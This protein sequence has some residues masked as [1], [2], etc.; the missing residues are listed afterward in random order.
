MNFREISHVVSKLG[1]GPIWNPQDNCVTWTDISQKVIH[2]AD[3]DSGITKSLSSKNMIGALAFTRD[4]NLVAA[5]QEGFAL[6]DTNGVFSELNSFLSSDMRM[7][8]GKVDPNGRFWAGS[9]ALDFEKNR[10]SLYV[11]ERD[12][13][14]KKVLD[15]IT[16][17]NGMGWS[18][19]QKYFYFIDSI[20]GV[21]KRFDYDSE[22]GKIQNQVDLIVFDTDLGIPDG[23]SVCS[24]GKLVVA[25]WDGSRVEIYEPSGEKCGQICLEV[26]R[27]TSCTFGG[28][29]LDVLIVT[30][31]SQD[32]NLQNEVLAGKTLAITESGLSGQIAFR[33][34]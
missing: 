3:L 21:L 22:S 18:P 15:N 13:S 23:M 26:S 27:P 24:D 9:M 14:V 25:L 20:P 17:S 1:E 6:I 12:G 10:G 5:T 29:N 28:A 30:S 34:G 8:D 32:I 31:A 2:T 16:L 4:G 33:Y 7:N 11:L 19:D